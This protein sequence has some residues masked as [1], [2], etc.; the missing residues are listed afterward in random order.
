VGDA[1]GARSLPLGIKGSV[2]RSLPAI[3]EEET[4]PGIEGLFPT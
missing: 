2:A 1:D 3:F 4:S